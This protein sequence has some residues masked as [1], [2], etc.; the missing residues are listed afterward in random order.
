MVDSLHVKANPVGV[1]VRT[2][3][4]QRSRSSR[5]VEPDVPF[6][7]S[8]YLRRSTRAVSVAKGKGGNRSGVS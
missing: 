4:R 1:Q 7:P 3:A 8:P 2:S 6:N 5:T